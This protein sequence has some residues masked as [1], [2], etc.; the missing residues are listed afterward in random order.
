MSFLQDFNQAFGE[1]F[2]EGPEDRNAAFRLA[3]EYRG[4]DPDAPMGRSTI[5]NNAAINSV[6]QAFN[7]ADP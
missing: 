7:L 1:G 6:K 5:G 3:R 4:D 2:G